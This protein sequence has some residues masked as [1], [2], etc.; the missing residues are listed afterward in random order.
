MAAIEPIDLPETP[1][2]IGENFPV[3]DETA[4]TRE[5]QAQRTAAERA[6]GA[7]GAALS[8]ASY[9]TPEFRGRGG[10]TLATK[11]TGHH[12]ALTADQTRH[13]NVAAWLESAAA[14]ITDTKTLMNKVSSDYHSDYD[15]MTQRAHDEGWNQHQLRTAKKVLVGQAQQQVQHARVAFETRHQ[16]VSAGVV[17]GDAPDATATQHAGQ[18][19]PTVQAAG[20]R[21]APQNG[22]W[23]L[24][25]GEWE[26]DEFGSPQP[27]WPTG[28]GG[29]GA[30]G[31]GTGGTAPI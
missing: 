20:F 8:A 5:A 12:E 7:G 3:H 6:A 26:L 19:E 30:S 24:E 14:N 21:P 11:L 4:Y 17:S 31:S 15:T 28:G 22:P 23:G 1:L 9:T 2:I 18:N 13:L 16:A 10:G 27:V 25:D 29:G